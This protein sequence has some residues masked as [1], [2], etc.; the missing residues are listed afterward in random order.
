MEFVIVSRGSLLL[1]IGHARSGSLLSLEGV[2]AID[3]SVAI[4][5]SSA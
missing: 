5:Q 2:R 4:A 3:L 1:V